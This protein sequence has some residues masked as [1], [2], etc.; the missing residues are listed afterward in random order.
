MLVRLCYVIILRYGCK[1]Q[2]YS[3]CVAFV[4][5]QY[6]LMLVL[7]G[8]IEFSDQLILIVI[9]TTSGD[10]FETE[11]KCKCTTHLLSAP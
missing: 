7:I 1:M 8:F 2:I 3:V 5:F 4:Q 11:C 6:V 9:L 10:N